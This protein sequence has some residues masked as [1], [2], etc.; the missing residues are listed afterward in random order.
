M[1]VTLPAQFCSASP[2]PGCPAVSVAQCS[3]GSAWKA[4]LANVGS[5]LQ[6][7]AEPATMAAGLELKA[8][9]KRVLHSLLIIRME[10]TEGTEEQAANACFVFL[11]TIS[12][13]PSP[14]FPFFLS[15]ALNPC[16]G[17]VLRS[18][19][20]NKF[21]REKYQFLFYSWIRFD[22]IMDSKISI[23]SL[24]IYQR[25]HCLEGG[26]CRTFCVCIAAKAALAGA[27]CF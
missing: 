3:D 25:S 22:H 13:L 27:V 18:S 26:E 20:E 11:C 12:G 19:S 16:T 1:E 21:V 2:G 8:F 15:A 5:S 10:G 14:Q 6:G 23:G 4:A 9:E 7:G 17:C 24:L